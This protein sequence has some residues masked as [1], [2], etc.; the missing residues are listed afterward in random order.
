MTG[1][2]WLILS[3]ALALCGSA[4]EAADFSQSNF[5]TMPDGTAVPSVTLVNR[6]GVS[7]TV[8]ALGAS[9]QSVIVPDAK[10]HKDD[11]LLGHATLDDYLAKRQFMGATVG[12]VAN[13]I[14][15]GRFSLDG[16]DYQVTQNDGTNALHGGKMG[17]DQSVWHVAPPVTDR[18]AAEV[19]FQHVSPDGDQGFPGALDISVTYRLDEHD[20]LTILYAAH[21]DRPTVVALSSH[22]YWNLAGEGSRFGALDQS[23]TIPAETYSPVDAGLIPT[24][25]FRPVAGTVFDFRQP[26]VIGARVRSSTDAQIKIGRGYDHNWVVTRTATAQPHLMAR[27][28]DPHSGRAMELWSDAPGVQFYSGNFLD[29]T[30]HGKAGQYYRQGD[31]IVLEPQAFPDTVNHASFGSVRLAAGATYHSTIIYKFTHQ[32]LK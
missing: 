10:G 3:A 30:T 1:H 18:D 21:A 15:N 17:L 28:S 8:I 13:R 25:E 27:V 16:R 7:V 24:G 20:Q 14:A 31:A 5:G 29:G 2:K 26:Q 4:V 12:R 11:I 22:G 19:T 23:L 6:H 32:R 9:L